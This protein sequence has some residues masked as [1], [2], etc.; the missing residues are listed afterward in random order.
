MNKKIAIETLLRHQDALRARGVQHAALFGSVAR[1]KAGAESDLDI[2]VEI[3]PEAKI[4]I[5]KY[6]GLKR[7]IEELFP[8]RVD[9]V[10]REALKPLI[11]GRA[12]SDAVYAF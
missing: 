12:E 6:A 11:R 5:F 1:G 7:F 9:V 4:D 3:S 10:D 8:G 2:F